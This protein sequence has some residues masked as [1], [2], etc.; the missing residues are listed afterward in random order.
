MLAAVFAALLAQC[1]DE[2]EPDTT[3]VSMGV[4][5]HALAIVAAE[6]AFADAK[7]AALA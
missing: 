7:L 2:Y 3:C 5:A 4:S 6:L 1:S